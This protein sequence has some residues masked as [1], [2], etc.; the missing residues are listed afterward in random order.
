MTA[1]EDRIVTDPYSFLL[2]PSPKS[3]CGCQALTVEAGKAVKESPEG[4]VYRRLAEPVTAGVYECNVNCACSST[5]CLN[6]VAQRP[7]RNQ[8]QVLHHS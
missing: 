7:L 4:Y 3:S 1:G 5:T 6:R 8:L 2:L